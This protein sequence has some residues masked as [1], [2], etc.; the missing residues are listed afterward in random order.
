MDLAVSTPGPA[1]AA[2]EPDTATGTDTFGYQS[3]TESPG[4][5]SSRAAPVASAGL[6]PRQIAFANGAS[7]NRDATAPGGGGAAP[8]EP[9]RR[10]CGDGFYTRREFD[11]FFGDDELSATQWAGAAASVQDGAP[12]GAPLAADPTPAAGDGTPSDAV[13]S[14]ARDIGA[15]AG[16]AE[17]QVAGIA[18]DAERRQAEAVLRVVCRA[19]A[20][21]MGLQRLRE[22]ASALRALGSVRAPARARLRG[23]AA[24]PHAWADSRRRRRD[25]GSSGPLGDGG[26]GTISD[27][28]SAGRAPFAPPCDLAGSVRDSARPRLGSPL[29]SGRRRRPRVDDARGAPAPLIPPA[30]AV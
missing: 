29:D 9:E 23:P 22:V 10:W 20:A 6:A 25:P 15:L 17:A 27:G 1:A 4:F 28:R 24:P 11:E 26:R 2:P 14:A 8:P 13:A 12:A 30:P 7:P 5:D 21:P 16:V 3:S 19:A 18:G